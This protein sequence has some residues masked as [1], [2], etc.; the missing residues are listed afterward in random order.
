MST[1]RKY[2]TSRLGYRGGAALTATALAIALGVLFT[3]NVATAAVGGPT[4][5]VPGD[6]ATIAS[7]LAEAGCTTID[8]A[9]GTYTG[10]VVVSRA[11]ILNGANAGIDPN[12]GT[13]GD[14]STISS[15]NGQ[16]A[17]D[18]GA[19][20]VVVDGFTLTHSS[21][22]TGN[23]GAYG[24]DVDAV[25]SGA[26]I[27]NNII[28]DTNAAVAEGSGSQA[29][30][31]AIDLINGPD[32]VVIA[33]NLIE[34]VSSDRSAKAVFISDSLATNASNV[35][36]VEKNVIMDVTSTEKGA[37]GVTVNNGSHTVGS[38]QNSLLVVKDNN[39]HDLT[40]AWVHA[41]GIEADAPEAIVEGNSF[42]NLTASGAD[43]VAV[44]F[45]NEDPSYSSSKVNGN[46]FNF[47]SGSGIYGIAVD[48]ALSPGSLDGTCNYWGSATGPGSVGP[49]KGALV[50][51][52][53]NFKPWEKTAGGPCALK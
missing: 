10:P 6:Y 11:V 32:G 26:V 49:G 25:A 31:Q 27:T 12:T 13:R 14:E 1:A 16:F 46:S 34:N 8:V 33:H 48:P 44:W 5:S 18:I 20:D 47:T 4:C 23:N 22:A 52:L 43:K 7:A 2:W 24:I 51:P 35:V 9:P 21:P 50:S 41:V 15:P 3:A 53:V 17:I 28:T 29:T 39:I 42:S 40:G 37:Y 19:S 38:T 30:A 45:E 36:I